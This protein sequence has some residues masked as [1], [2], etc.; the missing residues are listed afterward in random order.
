MKP[1]PPRGSVL[2]TE[3]IICDACMCCHPLFVWTPLFRRV[4][5]MYVKRRGRIDRPWEVVPQTAAGAGITR[6]PRFVFVFLFFSR[7]LSAVLFCLSQFFFPTQH[8]L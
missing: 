4:L 5:E 1:E 2:V 6:T 7:L 3:N 8:M